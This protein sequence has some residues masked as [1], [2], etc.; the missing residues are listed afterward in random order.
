MHFDESHFASAVKRD[1]TQIE[2]RQ[3]V[4]DSNVTDSNCDSSLEFQEPVEQ[5]KI[6][7]SSPPTTVITSLVNGTSQIITSST[8]S[9]K[10]PQ[11][12]HLVGNSINVS[13]NEF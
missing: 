2:I 5:M 9:W 12:S 3:R 11:M 4:S 10:V 13:T 7:S 6:H 1:W 8:Y